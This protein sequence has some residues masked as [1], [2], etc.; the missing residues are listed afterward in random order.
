M[1]ARDENA[2]T[3]STGLTKLEHDTK[4]AWNPPFKGC[5]LPSLHRYE[6]SKLALHLSERR[7]NVLVMITQPAPPG[8]CYSPALLPPASSVLDLVSRSG[9]ASSN[10]RGVYISLCSLRGAR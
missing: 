6:Y 1:A 3:L 2:N 7:S 10:N 9:H 5:L 8:R 4:E